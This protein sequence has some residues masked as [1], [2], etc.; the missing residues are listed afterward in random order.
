MIGPISCCV[1]F[2]VHRAAGDKLFIILRDGACA[3]GFAP[4]FFVRC[5]VISRCC[6]A[7]RILQILTNVGSIHIGFCIQ[8]CFG[9]FSRLRY[10]QQ[11][12]FRS[13]T[14]FDIIGIIHT[15]GR[16]SKTI[17]I[18]SFCHSCTGY[19]LSIFIH[20]GQFSLRKMG[21]SHTVDVGFTFLTVEADF[22]T[23][24]NSRSIATVDDDLIIIGGAQ[25]NF[26]R[27]L[28][29]IGH[30]ACLSIGA[31]VEQQAAAA[32]DRIAPGICCAGSL[33]FYSE[34]RMGTGFLSSVV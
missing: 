13:G 33:P 5:L 10:G 15:P 25:G 11:L 27:Q 12:V 23:Y 2:T 31:F 9:F 6:V 18:I 30:L 34:R 1:G 4:F 17:G 16:I 19:R 21:N 28:Q 29:I 20:I 14:A 7:I 22:F 3:D 24:F 8:S 26:I 32:V